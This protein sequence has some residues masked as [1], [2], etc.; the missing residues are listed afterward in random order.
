MVRFISVSVVI[1]ALGGSNS[2]TKITTNADI[3]IIGMSASIRHPSGV[4]HKSIARESVTCDL[5][6]GNDSAIYQSS[7]PPDIFDMVEAFNSS[8]IHQMITKSTDILATMKHYGGTIISSVPITVSL[9]LAVVNASEYEQ[10][11]R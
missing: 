11:R 8:G 4:L 5:K 3:V 2:N 10:Y 1:E 6:F 7:S 9:V